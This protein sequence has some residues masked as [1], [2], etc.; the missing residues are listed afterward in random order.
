MHFNRSWMAVAYRYRTCADH[1]EEFKT[2][3]RSASD[4]WKEWGEDEEQNYKLER[5]LYGFFMNGLSIF[6]SFGFCLYFVGAAQQPRN[7]PH[8]TEPKKITLEK[9]AKAFD[10]A[11]PHLSIATRLAAL[12]QEKDFK[13]IDGVRN[14]LAHRLGGRRNVSGSSVIQRD[15]TSTHTRKEVW[16]V[17]GSNDELIFDDQMTQRCL[18]GITSL[19]T[20]L[21][22]ASIEFAKKSKSAKA[23]V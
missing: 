23:S 12:P 10:A 5:C 19:L 18:D 14:I 9:T 6:E 22:E 20:S 17:P 15:G 1:S 3:V 21:V 4:L 13:R 8:V 11:F 16:H 2:L 7:F